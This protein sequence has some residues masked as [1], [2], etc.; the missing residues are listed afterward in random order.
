MSLANL[1]VPNSY[2]LFIDNAQIGNAQLTNAEI[3]DGLTLA[4]PEAGYVPSTFNL[5][6]EYI[7]NAVFTGAFSSTIVNGLFVQRINDYVKV[8]IIGNTLQ[9]T[10]TS[11]LFI[12]IPARFIPKRPGL[13]TSLIPVQT[14]GGASPTMATGSAVVNLTD[15]NFVTIYAN[16]Y[17]GNNAANNGSFTSGANVGILDEITFGYWLN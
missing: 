15:G 13:R 10:A 1:L 4:N 7:G 11:P 2:S 3:A 9:A 17:N 5:F 16:N 8:S 6:E 12:A 14:A